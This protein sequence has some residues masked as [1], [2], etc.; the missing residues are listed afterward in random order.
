MSR[1]TA[2]RLDGWKAIAVYLRCDVATVQRWE[3]ERGLPVRRVPGGSVRS[4]FA[5]RGEIDRWLG[6]RNETAGRQNKSSR[7]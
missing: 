6:D 3:R 1:E 7:P 4:V 5:L 2:E